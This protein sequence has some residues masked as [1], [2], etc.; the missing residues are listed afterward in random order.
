MDDKQIIGLFF[1]RQE[2][3]IRETA[4]KYGRLCRKVSYNILHNEQDTDECVNTSYQKLWDSV[5]PKN[6]SSLCGYLCAIVRNTALNICRR[7]NRRGEGFYEDLSEVLPDSNTVEA[8]YDSKQIAVL[9]NEFLAGIG[10]KNRQV[11]T[12]RY[13][14]GMSVK[15]ICEGFDMSENAVKSRLSRVRSELRTYL[16]ERGIDV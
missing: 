14:L 16:M 2:E 3:A 4:E 7:E 8:A 12:A 10:K 5:P 6:P 1:S 11:F 9:I 13:Y 15:S